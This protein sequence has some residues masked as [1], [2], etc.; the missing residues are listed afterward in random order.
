V[1][2]AHALC[3]LAC[4]QHHSLCR[5]MCCVP[6]CACQPASWM[7]GFSCVKVSTAV[8]RLAWQLLCSNVHGKLRRSSACVVLAHSSRA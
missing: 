4:Q 7:L 2:P 1:L 3:V 6:A 5:V 8:D